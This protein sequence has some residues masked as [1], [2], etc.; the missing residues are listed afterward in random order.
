MT[1]VSCQGPVSTGKALRGCTGTALA[2]QVDSQNS[3]Y[4]QHSPASGSPITGKTELRT[5]SNGSSLRKRSIAG[6]IPEQPEHAAK[7]EIQRSCTFENLKVRFAEELGNADAPAVVRCADVQLFSGQCLPQRMYETLFQIT[8]RN[9]EVLYNDSAPYWSWN[10]DKKREEIRN[11]NMRYIL[12]S[13]PKSDAQV[14]NDVLREVI[15]NVE[16]STPQPPGGVFT[17]QPE[18]ADENVLGFVGFTLSEQLNIRHVYIHELQL[19]AKSRGQGVGSFLMRLVEGIGR[20]LGMRLILLTALANNGGAIRF[21]NKL[22]FSVDEVSPGPCFS[23]TNSKHEIMSKVLDRKLLRYNCTVRGCRVGFRFKD[24]LH[25]HRCSKHGHAWP[26]PCTQ[27][28][29]K[30]SGVIRLYQHVR[31]LEYK[32]GIIV[33]ASN[34]AKKRRKRRSIL[35][36]PRPSSKQRKRSATSGAAPDNDYVLALKLQENEIRRSDCNKSPLTGEHPI[37]SEPT[38]SRSGEPLEQHPPVQAEAQ[39]INTND[40][41]QQPCLPA[42]GSKPT[43]VSEGSSTSGGVV[44]KAQASGLEESCTEGQ[45]LIS[46]RSSPEVLK[47]SKKSKTKVVDPDWLFALELQVSAEITAVQL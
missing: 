3:K 20:T 9:M 15:S 30:S 42:E 26:Y 14:C 17:P 22:G 12:V 38:S 13:C 27:P 43:V 33:E 41:E 36:A 34:L 4:A 10:D 35:L 47:K 5:R 19:V 46:R 40:N 21:Y 6:I 29:C 2:F 11:V 32:H 18:E 45:P 25:R 24:S 28:D 8:K 16:R 37:T 31:H 23:I 44:Q 7:E 1:L 39:G